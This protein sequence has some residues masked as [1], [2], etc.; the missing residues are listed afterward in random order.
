MVGPAHPLLAIAS[1]VLLENHAL[2]QQLAVLKRKHPKPWMGA[3]DKIF[4]VFA[5]RFWSAW[6]QP[7]VLVHPETVV[8]W[9]RA[10]FRLHWRLISRVRNRVGRPKLSKDVR[11][12]IFRMVARR[13]AETRF[14][15]FRADGF[16]LASARAQELRCAQALADF[17]TQPRRGHCGHGLL[18]RAD[19]HFRSF[20]LL[21]RDSHGRRKILRCNVTRNSSALW[22][23]QQMREA[24]PYARAQRFLLFD[25]G[26]Q[27][28]ART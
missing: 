1:N 18:H 7:L 14:Q 15:G 16:A 12:L 28:S 20:V 19:A 25:I 3:V 5:R 2:R 26:M 4:W 8:R 21:L 10:G 23:G 17:P 6:K 9:H 27:N 11:D 24:W 13:I 22:I